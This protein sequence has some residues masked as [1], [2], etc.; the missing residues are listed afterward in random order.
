[1]EEATVTSHE[2]PADN[3]YE[4][5]AQI[6]LLAFTGRID[7]ASTWTAKSIAIDRNMFLIDP[8]VTARRRRSNRGAAMK[9]M[10][11]VCAGRD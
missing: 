7:Y 6:S 4:V 9:K 5:N 11:A 2:M 3:T 8:A 1:M 10:I